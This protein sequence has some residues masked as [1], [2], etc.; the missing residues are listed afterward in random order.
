MDTTHLISV[1]QIQYFTP[2]ELGNKLDDKVS[3][4]KINKQL[5]SKGMQIS[6]RGS[7]KKLI[8]TVTGKV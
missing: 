4:V 8:W 5:E 1:N 2:T 3:A 7:K 6:S